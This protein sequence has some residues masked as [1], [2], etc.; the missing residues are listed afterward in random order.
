MKKWK[1]KKGDEN[2]NEVKNEKEEKSEEIHSK[3]K[4]GLKHGSENFSLI[5]ENAKKNKELKQTSK[6]EETFFEIKFF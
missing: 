6:R 5:F 4:R 2:K 3:T 1:K